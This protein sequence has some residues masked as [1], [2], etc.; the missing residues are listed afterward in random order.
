MKVC[1]FVSG[2]GSNMQALAAGLKSSGAG[3]VS[4]VVSDR[5]C[6]AAE[7]AAALG[8]PFEKISPKNFSS[9]VVYSSRLSSLM[10][11]NGIGLICLAGYLSKLPENF[12]SE[13]YGRIINVHPSLLPAF[14]GAGYYGRRVH[15]AVIKSGAKISGVTVHFVNAVY[16]AGPIITQQPV[17][18]SEDETPDTLAEKINRVELFLYPRAAELFC[19][20]L[21][22]LEN[23]KAVVLAE[24]EEKRSRAALISVSDKTGLKEFAS[25]LVS[26]GIRLIATGG[27]FNFLR[28]KGLPVTAVES[29]TSYP[30][31]LDG[32]V[33]TLNNKIFAGLLYKR[34]NTSHISQAAENWVPGLDFAVVNLYPFGETAASEENWSEKLIENIDIGGVSLLRAAAKNYS[35]SCPICDPSDYPLV[36]S[37][38]AESG[39]LSEQTSRKMAVK[40][41][42][43]TAAYDKAIFE[44]L[45][46]GENFS[47]SA[48]K[49]MDLRYGENPHQKAALYS[50]ASRLPFEKIQGKELSYNNLLDIY[51][52]FLAVKDFEE[53]ACVIFKHVT[54][55]AMATGSTHAEAFL[56]AWACDPLSAFGGIIAVNGRIDAD[57]AAFISKKFVEVVVASDFETAALEILKK[58][59]N[60]R[61]IKFFGEISSIPIFRSLG[62]EILVCSADD[63]V[64]G[65]KWEEVSG[66]VSAEEKKALKFAFT[67]VKHVRSNAIV[68]SDGFSACGIGSGQ[69]SRVDSVFMAGHKYQLWLKQNPAPQR[70]VMASDAFFPFEDAI[71]EAARIGV[72][73][74]I[75]PGGSLRDREVIEAAKKLNI[76]MVLTGIRHFR[77]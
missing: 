65:E 14:G 46:G 70:L 63:K 2:R 16:D 77:H 61:V 73:A 4:L 3:L 19:K 30:E 49:I 22:K 6:P 47:V 67:C 52:S 23:G 66:S 8:I 35:G 12:I 54:P 28:E 64:L 43:H 18:L 62:E 21:I 38:L 45:S 1:V 69:M 36:L 24:G 56:R 55:C 15:E 60:L 11:E 44:K 53:P 26:L 31:I 76:K 29:I 34:D 50:S 25:G 9:E 40:A 17:F 75:Q 74:I 58:K 33:K 57:T 68:L 27:T 42:A 48:P 32:R 71:E 37:E 13:Y 59:Q 39:R 72:S 5:D 51:G 20:G 10:K 41:F 7:K